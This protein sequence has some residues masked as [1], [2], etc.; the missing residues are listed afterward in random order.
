MARRVALYSHDAQGLGHMRR[1]A[2]IARALGG[3]ASSILLLAGAR[4]AARF[5][6]PDGIDTLA[7]PA[8]SKDG[9]GGYRARSLG[10][11]GAAIAILREQVL[12]AALVTFAPDVLIVDKL[13][14]GVNGELVRS[15]REVRAAGTRL[16]LGM[17]EVLD[18]P[19]QTR[20]DWGRDRSLAAL[21]LYYDAVW[22]YGDP[23]VYDPVAEYDIPEDI[24][25]LVR[26]TGYL[27]RE[28]SERPTRSQAAAWR[29]RLGLGDRRLCLCAVGGG[30]DGFRLARA[31]A[32]SEIPRGSVGAIVTGPFMP[33]KQRAALLAQRRDDM[34]LLDFAPDA[35]ALVW[36]ADRVIAMGGYNTSCEILSSR[37]RALIVPRITPRREQLIRAERLSALGAVDLLMPHELSPGALSRWLGAPARSPRELVPPIDLGGLR[38][39]PALLQ[40]LM[41][42]LA[43]EVETSPPARLDGPARVAPALAAPPE[44]V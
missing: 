15:F 30:E 18:T 44:A 24:G 39:V 6:L 7:L 11:D 31:F 1:N 34:R 23:R 21:R 25:A 42:D 14:T 22:V 13:A 37:T 17:R 35:D 32:S 38:R 41:S 4:Q 8:L 10:I 28:Q 36:L 20:A 29:E 19:E 9:R 3:E 2:A 33:E 12:R 43:V 40:D 26:Y 16:V 27:G 5:P